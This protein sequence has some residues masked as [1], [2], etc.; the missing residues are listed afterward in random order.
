MFTKCLPCQ[1]RLA[2]T[3]EC[4]QGPCS[5]WGGSLKPTAFWFSVRALPLGAA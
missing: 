2:T 5:P 3:R 1:I 4:V